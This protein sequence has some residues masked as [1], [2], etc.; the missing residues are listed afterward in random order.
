MKLSLIFFTCTNQDRSQQENFVGRPMFH[1]CDNCNHYANKQ[2][3]NPNRDVEGGGV[4]DAVD[5]KLP[6]IGLSPMA[7]PSSIFNLHS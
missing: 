3:N 7:T 4:K 1:K 2:E 5:V 6:P